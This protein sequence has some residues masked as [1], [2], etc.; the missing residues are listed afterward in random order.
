MAA[1]ISVVINTL[2]EERRLPYALRSV[3]GWVD[4]IVVVDMQSDDRT[5]EIAEASGARVFAHERLGY[6]DPARAF[7]IAKA[8]GDWI[9][10][11]DADE[12][13]PP[14]LA[15]R[16]S[17]IAAADEADVVDLPRFNYLLGEPLAWTG[18]GPAQDHHQRFFRRGWVES[19]GD[20]HNFLRIREGAR[21][22][23]LAPDRGLALVHFAYTDVSDFIERLNRYTT[24]EAVGRTAGRHRVRRARA[25]AA[26]ILE[27]TNRFLRHKG[28]RDGWRGFYLAGLMAFY[29]FA[30]YAKE[31]EST[32]I[33]TREDVEHLYEAEAE[34]WLSDQRADQ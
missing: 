21:V 12:L 33:G 6:A 3:Q 28:Y 31:Q 2:N 16:L 5:V 9:L 13:V 27:F 29:R 30:V 19:T 1:R 15:R 32:S 11:L 17:N 10:I 23:R 7:A 20:I 24:I 25:I 22:L 8:T 18:W 4:E 26:T 14:R 34:R